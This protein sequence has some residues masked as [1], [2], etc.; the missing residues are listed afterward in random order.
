VSQSKIENP[1][2]KILLVGPATNTHVERWTVALRERGWR[3]SI[4]STEPLPSMV[5][6]WL[7]DVPCFVIPTAT[8]GMSAAQR[9]VTLL[10][11]WAKVPGLVAAL[12]PDLVHVHSLPT[13]LATPFLR[14]VPRLVVSAWGSDV[15]QRDGRKARWYPRLLAHAAR[16]TATS[17]Y[18]AGVVQT[19]LPRQVDIVPFG[20]DVHRFVPPLQPSTG[21]RVGTMRHLEHNYGI[22]VLLQAMP[23]IDTI[24]SQNIL[25]QIGG[26]GSLAEALRAQTAALGITDQAQWL[27]RVPH[28]DVPHFLQ[29]LS[30]FAMPSRAES[31]G[32]AALEAQACGVPVV[33]SHVGGL[34]EVV[35]HGETGLLVPPEDPHALAEAIAALL[36]HG[37]W[38]ATMSAAA[39]RWVAQ[40]YRWE[41]SVALME[42]VYCEAKG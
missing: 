18:L 36:L 31:F 42:D 15:V 41:N 7:R 28:G 21:L 33:A 12:K 23:I 22:D 40:R 10:R 37:E 32:V 17:Q 24:I 27:G 9:L 16:V 1:K 39:R 14:R 29:Q 3:V 30:V 4:L 8:A 38:R 25:L 20:V 11:G 5:P 2:S 34:P 13:P 35:S 6:P 26:A 19:Y